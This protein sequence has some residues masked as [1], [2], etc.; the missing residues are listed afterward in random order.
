MFQRG[1]SLSPCCYFDSSG[2]QSI[3][4]RRSRRAPGTMGGSPGRIMLLFFTRCSAVPI[5]GVVTLF[6]GGMITFVWPGRNT[7][8]LAQGQ[9]VQHSAKRIHETLAN[10]VDYSGLASCRRSIAHHYT[11]RTGR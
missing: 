2:V 10:A 8:A 6:A 11:S 7:L 9:S 3:R 1:N 5:A 4:R